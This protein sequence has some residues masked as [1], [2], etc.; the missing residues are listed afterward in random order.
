MSLNGCGEVGRA[1]SLRYG[2]RK[3]ESRPKGRLSLRV[4]RR[5]ESYLRRRKTNRAAAP[6]PASAR[7]EGSGTPFRLKEVSF[8]ANDV[9]T[10]GGCAFGS[11]VVSE[12]TWDAPHVFM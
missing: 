12:N 11:P 3:R 2:C 5:R 9:G 7:L 8:P 4:Y 1:E 10:P 6:S